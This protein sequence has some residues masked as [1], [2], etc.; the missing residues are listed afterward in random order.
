MARHG[1]AIGDLV[2]NAKWHRCNGWRGRY[3][4]V[5][6]SVVEFAIR[7]EVALATRRLEFVAPNGVGYSRTPC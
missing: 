1:V 5:P 2:G 6:W 4:V 3:L 7:T